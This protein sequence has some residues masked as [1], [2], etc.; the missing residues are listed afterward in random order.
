MSR[1][2]AF[3]WGYGHYVVFGS[4]GA[5]GAG[6][7]LAAASS[8]GAVIVSGGDHGGAGGRR[9]GGGVSSS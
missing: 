1:Q 5:L 6:L 2:L 3:V 9:S 4:L 8:H 7:Q